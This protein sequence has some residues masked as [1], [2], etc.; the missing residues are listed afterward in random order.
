[1]SPARHN[2]LVLGREVGP[3]VLKRVVQALG[4]PGVDEEL[5]VGV[6]STLF[7]DRQ[8]VD[9]DV[10]DLIDSDQVRRDTTHTVGCEVGI[11]ESDLNTFSIRFFIPK[12][13][14]MEPA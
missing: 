13:D 7:D 11:P 4:S 1:M 9:Q 3:V 5:V 6:G 14:M 10:L 8:V 12:Q 2:P